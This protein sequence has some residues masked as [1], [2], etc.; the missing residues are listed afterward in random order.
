[1]P[2]TEQLFAGNFIQKVRGLVASESLKIERLPKWVTSAHV[3]IG[4]LN[5]S[6]VFLFEDS[7]SDK[8]EIVFLGDFCSDLQFFLR[9]PEYLVTGTSLR[10]PAKGT[11]GMAVIFGEYD[12]EGKV[13]LNVRS[14]NSALFNVGYIPYHIPMSLVNIL[15]QL[16]PLESI[17]ATRFVPFAIYVHDKDLANFENFWSMASRSMKDMLLSLHNSK[18]GDYYQQLT[19]RRQVFLLTKE[20][21]VIVFGKYGNNEINELN[22]VRDYLSKNYDAYLLRE[23]PEH[24]SMSLEEKVRL[25]ASAS[26][27][28]VMVDR[29]PSGHLVEYPYLKSS[30]AVLALLRPKHRGSTAMIEDESANFP[31]IKIFTFRRSPFEVIDTAVT[32]AEDFLN[33]RAEAKK[34]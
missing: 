1:M 12:K 24:P 9:L 7:P 2:S 19:E 34:K 10:A 15:I 20:R 33:K 13:I 22:Q 6:N 32:W 28:S 30:M 26:R 25:W 29:E 16:N 17:L 8:D 4:K 5:N 23:L 27:F 31:F 18:A 14:P 11:I 3:E 21:S